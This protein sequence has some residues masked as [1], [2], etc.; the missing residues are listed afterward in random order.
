MSAYG[1]VCAHGRCVRA[2]LRASLHS[3]ALGKAQE[4]LTGRKFDVIMM[5]PPWQLASSNPTRGVRIRPCAVWLA[6]MPSAVPSSPQVA[7]GYQQLGDSLIND[8]PISAVQDSGLIF[9]WVINAKYR[10][11]VTMLEKWG[12]RCVLHSVA[13]A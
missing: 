1:V 4:S 3:Q 12:Y 5:D 11:A 8:I 6:R 10:F 7:I 2:A 13:C 9:M